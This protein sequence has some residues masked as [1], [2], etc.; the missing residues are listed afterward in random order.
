MMRNK[1]RLVAHI[2]GDKDA[3]LIASKAP[4]V[5][6]F[7]QRVFLFLVASL[8]GYI[9]FSRDVIQAYVQARKTLERAVYIKTPH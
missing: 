9:G 4:T 8:P 6:R 3:T 5:Q 7:S 1:L 2:Y